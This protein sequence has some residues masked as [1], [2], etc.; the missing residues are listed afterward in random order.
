[1]L[2]H[3]PSA[4]TEKVPAVEPKRPVPSPRGSLRTRHAIQR[5]AAEREKGRIHGLD[6]LRALAVVLVIVYHISPS[7]APGGFIGVDVFFVISG[8]LIT[9]LLL[10]EYR[11][12]GRINLRQFYLRR[13]RRLLPAMVL[14]VAICTAAA[15]ALGG[16]VLS[17]LGLQLAGIATFTANWVQLAGSFDY[18]KTSTAGLFDNFWSLGIEEQ[19]Y[20]LWPVVL[21]AFLVRARLP[22]Q[23]F[24]RMR[25]HLVAVAL[26]SAL[27]MG[28]LVWFGYSN[29]AYLGTF[30]HLYGLLLGAALAMSPRMF[31]QRALAISTGTPT[32][33]VPPGAAGEVS[34]HAGAAE[35]SADPA[36][37]AG[38]SSPSSAGSAPASAASTAASPFSGMLHSAGRAGL[39]LILAL[40]GLAAVGVLAFSPLGEVPGRE[41]LLTLGGTVA[42]LLLVGACLVAP[43]HRARLLDSGVAG[44]I[45]TRSYGLYLWHFP[46][47]VLTDQLVATFGTPAGL[48][49]TQARILAVLVSVVAADLSYRFV[50]VPVRRNG[51]AFLAQ[52]PLRAAAAGLVVALLVSSAVW[53]H[54]RAPQQTTLEQT[55]SQGQA[56]T[57]SFGDDSTDADDSAEDQ[58]AA[59]P[60]NDTAESDEA[61]SD[62]AVSDEA[63]ADG[64]EAPDREADGQDAP[65]APEQDSAAQGSP[66][67]DSPAQDSTP[68]DST[69]ADAESAPSSSAAEPEPST[70]PH[71]PPAQTQPPAPEAADPPAR[72][73]QMVAVGDSV[74]LA[75]SEA[76]SRRFDVVIDAA[77]SRQLIHTPELVAQAV[78]Q[79]PAAS[80][81]IL[82]VGING[83]GGESDLRRAI[84][85]AGERTVVLVNIYGPMSFTAS[86][87]AMLQRVAAD[88]GHVVVADWHGWISGSTQ[89]LQADQVHPIGP[90]GDIYADAIA[91]AL[92]R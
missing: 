37:P 1:M 70:A 62:E 65:Q 71:T 67:Q 5:A 73:A 15:A 13:A 75:S 52:V 45:G 82:G 33:T 77:E 40:T 69:P 50:E 91:A 6:A 25:S 55:L 4:R 26:L 53:A 87:N 60:Q 39:S 83:V 54:T 90:G 17:G 16:D 23:A 92:G 51:F 68:Q 58:P 57:E 3:Q 85:N 61:V 27:L 22:R 44:W 49:H 41:P 2:T 10:R 9:S 46:L 89:H 81:V 64:A 74:M 76:M 20:L 59:A 12:H 21:I 88:Y 86:H 24:S 34:G 35:A 47:I 14:V 32:A 72:S 42:G 63:E 30:T 66:P 78:A 36:P 7:W 19:F 31:R 43:A 79:V 38:A 56:Y 80:T 11:D 28:A 29:A 48:D 84:T 18:F 8:F